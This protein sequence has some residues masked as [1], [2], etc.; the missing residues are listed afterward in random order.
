VDAA[1]HAAFGWLVLFI[2][3]AY[4]CRSP[5]L[6]ALSAIAINSSLM[7]L[8]LDVGRSLPYW[9]D[10]LV[11]ILPFAL[12]WAYDDTLWPF[13]AQPATTTAVTLVPNC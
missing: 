10:A 2:P 8:V 9:L 13:L 4:R 6:F 7:I 3:L 5:L 11:L 12:L 1:N